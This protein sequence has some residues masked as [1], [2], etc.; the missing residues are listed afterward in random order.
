MRC[1]PAAK[2][3]AL[4]LPLACA[5]APSAPPDALRDATGTAA[6][7]SSAPVITWRIPVSG[8]GLSLLSDGRYVNGAYSDYTGGVC[9]VE[10]TIFSGAG[11]S[12][13]AT[14]HAHPPQGGRCGRQYRL[15]YPDGSSELVA[16]FNNL[17]KLHNVAAYIPVGATQPRRLILNPGI[18]QPSRCGRVIFGDNGSVG[19]GTDMLNV[20]RVDGRTWQV[21]SQ[22]SPNDRALCESTGEILNLRVRFIVAADRDL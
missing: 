22:A 1:H 13:D 8:E 9:R 4:L 6:G 16:S 20:T 3:A 5:D 15:L 18:E 14:M 19:A 21:E 2:L 17:N 12:G 11:G 7:K 10:A